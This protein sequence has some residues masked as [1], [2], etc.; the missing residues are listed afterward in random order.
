M[1]STDFGQSTQTT[2]GRSGLCDSGDQVLNHDAGVILLAR[3]TLYM[4]FHFILKKIS[5]N[6]DCYLHFINEDTKIQKASD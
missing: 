1:V 5:K 3:N 2:C 4:L 6:G